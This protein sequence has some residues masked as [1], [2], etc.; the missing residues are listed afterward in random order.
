MKYWI[1]VIGTNL[2]YERFGNEDSNWFCLP[3]TSEVGDTLV[4]YATKNMESHRELLFT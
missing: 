1:G 2:T 3:R 4:L